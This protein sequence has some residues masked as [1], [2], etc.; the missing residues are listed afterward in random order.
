[1]LR[2]AS[3]KPQTH[4]T[5]ACARERPLF[6]HPIRADL[7]CVTPD[8]LATKSEERYRAAVLVIAS[9][10]ISAAAADPLT[11]VVLPFAHDAEVPASTAEL[12]QSVVTA[13]LARDPTL[14]V[15][16]SADVSR[17]L[18][19]SAD[20]ALMGCASDD[21]ACTVDVAAAL[22]ATHLVTGGVT[23][24]DDSLWSIALVI[25]DGETARRVASETVRAEGTLALSTRTRVGV[26]RLLAALRGDEPPP[27]PPLVVERR[28]SD[29]SALTAAATVGATTGLAT[30]ACLSP[31]AL[32]TTGIAA[33]VLGFSFLGPGALLLALVPPFVA[34]SSGAASL[35]GDLTNDEA[36]VTWARA[37]SAVVGGFAALAVTTPLVMGGALFLG[38][39]YTSSLGYTYDDPNDPIA[40]VPFMIALAL[41]P[42]LVIGAAA[43]GA[44]GSLVGVGL[45][46]D[47]RVLDEQ[48]NHA[49]EAAP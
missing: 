46:D 15:I 4:Q 11:L 14:T 39:L 18:D 49:T 19:L 21:G 42:L 28:M 2:R 36:S 41:S 29:A 47:P 8:P 16:S 37:G 35:V 9:L 30:V 40:L 32:L 23:R 31:W 1:M 48:V 22:G 34:A 26:A 33:G 13:A 38:A 17:L 20:R 44:T 43:G 12:A 45:F 10:L 3:L 27:M 24:T 7:S 25:V 6:T 5:N